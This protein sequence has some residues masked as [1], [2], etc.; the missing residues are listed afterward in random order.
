MKGLVI[1]AVLAVALSCSAATARPCTQFDSQG[2][3]LVNGQ[4]FFPIGLYLYHW[5]D[6]VRKEVLSQGFNTVIYGVTPKNL[7]EL[8]A[9]NLY[10]IPYGTPEWLAVRHDPAILAWYLADEPEGWGKTPEMMV[11]EHEKIQS[12]DGTR[13]IGLCHFLWDALTKY[14][15]ASDY[16]L[17]DVYP[18]MPNHDGRIISISDHIEQLHA[19]HGP[20]FPVW[21]VIQIFGGP[22][23]DNGKWGMPTADEVRMMTYLALAHRAKGMMFFSYQPTFKETW[24][25]A[26][27][28]VTELKALTPFFI[29]RSKELPVKCS[30]G[31]MHCR[32]V[33]V[34]KSGLVILVNPTKAEI[35]ADVSIADL[36]VKTLRVIDFVRT[37]DCPTLPAPEGRISVSLPGYGVRVYQWGSPL[38]PTLSLKGRGSTSAGGER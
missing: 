24:A 27:Q 26:K 6:N 8:R 14:K 10:T 23:C 4:P 18:I 12:I 15:D 3:L 33:Q 35:R 36:P 7:P 22:T 13:P 29:S 16:V 1:A 32:C 9:N 5:D 2:T 30:D 34:G 11:A 25:A 20:S 21:P 17:S 38:T 37:L 31:G 19:I 28:M